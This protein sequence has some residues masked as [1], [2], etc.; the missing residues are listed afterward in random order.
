[1]YELALPSVI[2]PIAEEVPIVSVLL[3]ISRIPLV[4]VKVPVIVISFCALSVSPVLLMVTF[5][6]ERADV[7]SS[8]WLEPPLK[9]IVPDPGVKVPLIVIFPLKSKL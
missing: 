9:V 4:R 3:F 5:E 6:S 7:P 1:M 2:V 8:V